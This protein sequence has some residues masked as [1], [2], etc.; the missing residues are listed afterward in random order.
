MHTE[1]G[2]PFVGA[3]LERLKSFLSANGLDYDPGIS[4]SIVLME[5]DEICATASLDGGTVKCVAVSPMH[6]GEG[7]TAPI[8]TGVRDAAFSRGIT[9]LMLFTKP[10]NLMMFRDFGFH[11][12]VRTDRVLLMENRRDGLS[13]F[14]KELDRPDPQGETVGCIVANCNPFTQGH[15]YL[16]ETAARQVSTLHV[17]ILSERKGPFT[18]ETRMAL[19]QAGCQDLKN[20]YFH[21]T[22][23]YMVSSATFPSYFIKDKAQVDEIYCAA[24][25]KL[26]GERFVPALNITHRFVGTEP[27]CK[28]TE[29][30]NAQMKCILPQYGV[31]VVEI[32]RLDWSGDAISASRVR[33][34]WQAGDLSSLKPLVPDGTYNYLSTHAPTGD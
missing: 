30:Y 18:P 28:V 19:A 15:R 3:K 9:H 14:L 12:L 4:F 13:R 11:P 27:N 34:L 5:G 20:V 8:M 16:I 24:D 29:A 6:Q 17:F 23:P 22:G 7:L 1:T 33:T 2:T 25:L 31:S 10:G 21:P 26:F 32:P